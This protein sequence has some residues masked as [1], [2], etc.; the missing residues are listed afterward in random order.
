MSHRSDCEQVTWQKLR[1]LC[2]TCWRVKSNQEKLEKSS[3]GTDPHNPEDLKQRLGSWL[4]SPLVSCVRC[5]WNS[6]G[7]VN[8]KHWLLSRPP[9]MP[10]L[11]PTCSLQPLMCEGVCL[12]AGVETG[13]LESG[14]QSTLILI[15][16]ATKTRLCPDNSEVRIFLVE[17][18]DRQTFQV[19]DAKRKQKPWRTV[20]N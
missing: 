3:G 15:R 13:V 19:H 12:I 20:T 18:S 10:P 8:E 5:C 11:P 2:Y 9:L 7:K 6:V 14:N 17:I 4:S 16:P 1:K